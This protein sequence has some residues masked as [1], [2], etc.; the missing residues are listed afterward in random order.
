MSSRVLLIPQIQSKK[1]NFGKTSEDQ[2]YPMLP[3]PKDSWRIHGA[4]D[5]FEEASGKLHHE[6]PPPIIFITA[7]SLNIKLR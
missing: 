1:R 5:N 3:S 4:W 7:A 2:D 6:L